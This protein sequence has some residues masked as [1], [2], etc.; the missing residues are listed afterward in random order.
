MGQRL[1]IEVVSRGNVIASSYYHWSAYSFSAAELAIDAL[2]FACSGGPVEQPLITAIH[3]LEETGAGFNDYSID[4]AKENLG[5]DLTRF[6]RCLGRNEGILEISEQG[7]GGN[8][9]WEEG[10]VTI[11][12][13]AK[14]ADFQVCYS[15]SFDEYLRYRTQE[16]EDTV[17]EATEM[18]HSMPRYDFDFAALTVDD[19]ME[20]KGVIEGYP[21]GIVNGN[22]VVE[23]IG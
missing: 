2:L 6:N 18:I 14:T 10:R 4:Y 19:L 1:N 3:C 21:D 11:D 15:M 17:E 20:L 8:R 7:M 5:L 22:L 23:W 12:L 9:R 16:L 13:D